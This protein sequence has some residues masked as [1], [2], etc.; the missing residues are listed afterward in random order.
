LD[1]RERLIQTE[2]H[3]ELTDKQGKVT[4]HV[5][6]GDLE[7]TFEGEVEQVW[8]SLNRFFT[9][10]FP[11]LEL[12]KKVVLTAELSEL[13]KE[14]EDLVGVAPE[15]AYVLVP[16]KN[17]TD[18]ETLALNLL[19]AYIGHKLGV[20]ERDS[21]SKEEL[22]LRLG[23][24]AKI[25]S[26]RLGELCREGVVTKNEEGEYRL[27]AFGIRKIQRELFPKIRAKVF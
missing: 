16:T 19:A 13:I 23:K 6:Y 5:K 21:L 17:L 4:I 11:N 12:V 3:H 27:T 10:M 20:L 22:R 1:R 26:T 8:K 14:C 9:Q 24:S 7:Q 15:G 25:T 2:G 18:S